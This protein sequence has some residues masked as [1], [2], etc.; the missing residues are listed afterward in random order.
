MSRFFNIRCMPNSAE[1]T[2]FQG[3]NGLAP[4]WN[5]RQSF[6]GCECAGH[7]WMNRCV[8]AAELV[9]HESLMSVIALWLHEREHALALTPLMS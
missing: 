1:T 5:P 9:L 7:K 4:S 3:T 6:P 8:F 2:G